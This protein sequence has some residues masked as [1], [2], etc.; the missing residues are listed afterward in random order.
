MQNHWVDVKI[1]G[2]TLNL[3]ADT[4]SEFT[5]ITPDQYNQSMGPMNPPD[6]RLRTWGATDILDV[7][8]VLET[9]IQNGR[10]A[11]INSKIYIVEGHHAESEF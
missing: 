2:K 4:G 5:I 3:F 7:K 9:T 11:C 8:G 10:G 6:I 1:G